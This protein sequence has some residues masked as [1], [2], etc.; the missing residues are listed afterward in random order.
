M[1]R[2]LFDVASDELSASRIPITWSFTPLKLTDCPI[3]FAPLNSC[4]A[5]SGPTTIT[6]LAWSSSEALMNRPELTP[7]ERIVRHAGVVP[8]SVG[9]QFVDWYTS[10]TEDVDAG[11]TASMSGA[12]ARDWS[13]EASW[14]VRV[15]AEPK[16]PLVP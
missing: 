6:E 15:E 16:P 11:A 9:V 1:A 4:V 12:T 7:R 8:V 3:G 5:V 13:A 10:A 14:R 2:S